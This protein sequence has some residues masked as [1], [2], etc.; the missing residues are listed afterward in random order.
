MFPVL[1]SIG[2]LS[3]SSF[4]IFLAL[5]FLLGLFLIW[6]LTRAWDLDEE[7]VLDLI[8]IIFVGGMIFARVFFALENLP[9]F[10]SSPL[11]LIK[12]SKVPGFSFWG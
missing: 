6:R 3:V 4:G 5:G 10:T 8:L 7:K 1:F 12:F 11:N 2:S 9:Y